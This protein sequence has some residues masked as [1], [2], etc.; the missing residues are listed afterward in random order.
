[1]LKN[2]EPHIMNEKER[3]ELVRACKWVD[4]VAEGMPYEPSHDVLDK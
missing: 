2:K 4:E 3:A 1:M